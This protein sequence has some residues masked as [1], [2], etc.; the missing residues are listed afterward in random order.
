MDLQGEMMKISKYFAAPILV[1][2]FLVSGVANAATVNYNESVDGDLIYQDDLVGNAPHLGTLDLGVNTIIGSVS[3]EID[4]IDIFRFDVMSGTEITSASLSTVFDIGG[5]YDSTL[6]FWDVTGLSTS[7]YLYDG[8]G[9]PY[10]KSYNP[11]DIVDL[12]DAQP[13]YF[14][15]LSPL[16]SGSYVITLAGAHLTTTIQ[17][18]DAVNYQVTFEVASTSPVPI[19]AAVWLFGSG[20]LGLVGVARHKKS[21]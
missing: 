18:G 6:T 5:Y 16:Q 7:S 15:P 19:P 8:I 3:Y 14:S 13:L 10:A 20:M 1:A 9:F 11:G 12:F 17:P 21:A 4:T 2:V